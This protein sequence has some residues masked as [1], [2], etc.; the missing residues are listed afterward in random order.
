MSGALGG[1]GDQKR[2]DR[3]RPAPV[4]H[5]HVIETAVGDRYGYRDDL[6]GSRRHA[7]EVART[8]AQ[9]LATVAAGGRVETLLGPAGRYL[10]TTGR[11][12]DA[13]RLIAVEECDDPD[14]V[15]RDHGAG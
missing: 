14:C 3:A 15:D 8:R 2:K 5:Y 1:L 9:W 10:V 6:F 12:S 7:T 4:R 11:P 13:G